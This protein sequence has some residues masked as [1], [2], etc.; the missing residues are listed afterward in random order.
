MAASTD[1]VKRVYG[2]MCSPDTGAE[3]I[4][5]LDGG[6]TVGSISQRLRWQILSAFD[7]AGEEVVAQLLNG[8][9]VTPSQ[10][11]NFKAASLLGNK[12]GEFLT[13]LVAL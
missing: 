9:M 7:G 4:T 2:A 8:A 6:V 1:L 13:A 3:L 12:A 11:L 10:E 5:I